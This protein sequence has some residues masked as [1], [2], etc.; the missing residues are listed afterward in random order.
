[1]GDR[2]ASEE[3]CVW[4]KNTRDFR[5]CP[6]YDGL[7]QGWIEFASLNLAGEDQPA[8]VAHGSELSNVDAQGAA[9]ADAG[10]A[11]L[12]DPSPPLT[13]IE[14]SGDVERQ[15]AGGQAH[16]RRGSPERDGVRVGTRRGGGEVDG[17]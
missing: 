8:V 10:L 14:P 7:R 13:G 6:G 5:A 17:A 2:P 12:R 16:H 11:A 9:V 4:T 1:M 15:R 3:T